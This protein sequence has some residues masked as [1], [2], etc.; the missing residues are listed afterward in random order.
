[1]RLIGSIYK[2]KDARKFSYFLTNKGIENQCDIVSNEDQHC[3]IWIINEDESEK[4]ILWY[5]KFLDNPQNEKFHDLQHSPSPEKKK[6]R[7]RI[8]ILERYSPNTKISL[9]KISGF[10]LFLC[11][12]LF[13]LKVAVP[14]GMVTLR[15][16][17]YPIVTQSPIYE[18]LAYDYPQALEILSKL[19]NAY[20]LEAIEDPN[21]LPP[22]AQLLLGQQYDL[23]IWP[24][25][26]EL[27]IRYIKYPEVGLSYKGPMFE[28]IKEGQWWRI[29][30]PCLLHADLLH[31]IFNMMWLIMLGPALEQR[32]GKWRLILLILLTGVISNTAQYLMSGAN[33]IGFSGVITGMIGFIWMRQRKFPWE[34]YPIN[35]STIG[36]ITFFVLAMAGLQIISFV[37]EIRGYNQFTPLIANSAHI[38][39]A[40][41]GIILGYFNCFSLKS[42]KN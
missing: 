41:T 38:A 42:R 26:Y 25:F 35:K 39:G 29:F 33:F 13:I 15:T 5:E 31:L 18:H 34:G 22:E 9:G 24:G 14:G 40:F 3:N 6:T 10:F 28:K 16:K 11:V 4:A 37:M 30:S 23:Q 32:V 17:P 21:G 12:L 1:M 2:I 19:I 8:N 7:K 36:F 27:L 20:G